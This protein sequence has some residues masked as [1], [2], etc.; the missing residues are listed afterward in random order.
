MTACR[1]EW[2]K[3]SNVEIYSK[4]LKRW[5]KD[6]IINEIMIDKD[7]NH[8]GEWLHVYYGFNFDDKGRNKKIQRFNP[9]IRPTPHH[10]AQIQQQQLYFNNN[11]NNNNNNNQEEKKETEELTLNLSSNLHL[12]SNLFLKI[13]NIIIKRW[14]K[15]QI[16]NLIPKEIG[17]IIFYFFDDK[18][19]I[20]E[21]VVDDVDQNRKYKW[22]WL[23]WNDGSIIKN[24]DNRIIAYGTIYGGCSIVISKLIKQNIKKI[25]WHYQLNEIRTY[26]QG[27]V[28]KWI[29]SKKETN[30]KYQQYGFIATTAHSHDIFVHQNE[31]YTHKSPMHYHHD[32][33]RLYQDELV[34]FYTNKKSDKKISA[35][36]VRLWNVDLMKEY[37]HPVECNINIGL[38]SQLDNDDKD[39]FFGVKLQ[40]IPG[41]RE[42]FVVPS[43][44]KDGKQMTSQQLPRIITG[45]SNFNDKIKQNIT[46][47]KISL[48]F[49][50][51][52]LTFD[53]KPQGTLYYRNTIEYNHIDQIMEQDVLYRIKVDNNKYPFPQYSASLLSI[54]VE[55]ENEN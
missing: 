1:S 13:I 49:K 33:R 7:D 10:I 5:F 50:S 29:F 23:V 6:G 39:N 24:K 12:K 40:F 35:K 48:D 18:C 45:G 34:W 26:F 19:E 32:Q 28:K 27:R 52:T 31:V 53:I 46:D 21:F 38:T 25:T 43:A 37:K 11:N 3:D 20:N 42:S 30:G 17:D 36:E 51:N 15:R 54:H 22:I 9:N 55:K 4:K 16:T 8:K 14:T 47:I 2:D 44:I 41:Q